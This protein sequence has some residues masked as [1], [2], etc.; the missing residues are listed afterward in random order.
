MT[1]NIL[2][3]LLA[4]I[5]TQVG[6]QEII[7]LW[8][9]G[10]IPDA[11]ADATY[12]EDTI[13][14]K[15]G[16]P[17]VSRVTDPTLYVVRPAKGTTDRHAAVVICPGGG[18]LYLSY[19]EEGIDVANRLAKEGF[20]AFVLKYRLP[21][22]QIMKNKSIG[23]LQDAQRAIRLV[24]ANAKKYD[25]RPDRI[26]IMGFSAGAHLAASASTL[27]D[28]KVYDTTTD[29][30]SARPD[31]SVL[32]YGVLSLQTNKTHKGTRERLIGGTGKKE[33]DLEI[34]FSP[35]DNIDAATP[36]AFLFH[37]AD[38]NAVPPVLSNIYQ[39]R[40][41]AQGVCSEL[42]IFAQGKHGFGLGNGLR[43]AEW[44]DLFVGWYAE[45]F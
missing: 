45:N 3:I 30:T 35:I 44:V 2:S 31:F 42:H 41:Q 36:P 28:Q 27:Y 40:L 24:R 7:H 22:E 43:A 26:G 15:N 8:S 21:S 20:T 11:I 29:T 25:I 12:H 5:A 14:G 1:R 17:R 16:A 39:Q 38:D 37:A 34:R 9:E 32:G 10:N 19:N 4:L 18:Y 6:A 13:R 33:R 23:P